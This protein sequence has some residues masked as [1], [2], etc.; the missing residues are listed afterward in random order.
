MYPFSYAT[1]ISQNYIPLSHPRY[2]HHTKYI[3]KMEKPVIYVMTGSE[4]DIIELIRYCIN[5]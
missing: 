4:A 1:D 2:I 5:A 3:Q